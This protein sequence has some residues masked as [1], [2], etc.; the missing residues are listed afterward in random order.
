MK[1]F[2]SVAIQSLASRSYLDPIS[3]AKN[4][5]AFTDKAVPAALSERISAANSDDKAVIEFLSALANEYELSGV[6]GLKDRTGL[7]EFRYDAI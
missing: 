4:E 6:G 7:L 1:P 2:Q 3:L 5:I